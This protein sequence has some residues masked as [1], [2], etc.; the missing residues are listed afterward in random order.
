MLIEG[1]VAQSKSSFISHHIDW[2]IVVD[3]E[4][5]HVKTQVPMSQHILWDL[6]HPQAHFLASSLPCRQEERRRIDNLEGQLANL[7]RV[8][9]LGKS[10]V[11]QAHTFV[12]AI[13][14]GQICCSR[15]TRSSTSIHAIS[16]TKLS[17][18]STSGSALIVLIA[19]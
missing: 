7:A 12:N 16:S 8:N 19:S 1:V 10:K 5:C 14:T 15:F 18:S 6:P 3:N 4:V 9:E 11:S 17:V 2:N 13:L